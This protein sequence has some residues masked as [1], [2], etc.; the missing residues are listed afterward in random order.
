MSN[1]LPEPD[2]YIALSSINT[3]WLFELPE[4]SCFSQDYKSFLSNDFDPK[5]Y[6]N[7]TINS[8]SDGDGDITI[9]LAKLSFGIDNLNKQLHDQVTAH[10]EDL[11]TQAAGIRDLENVLSTVKEGV[12]SLNAAFDRLKENI[13]TPYA[14]IKNYTLQLERYQTASDLLRN[15]VRLFY[16]ARCLESQMAEIDNKKENRIEYFKAAPIIGELD[17]LLKEIDFEG[18]ELVQSQLPSI[19]KAKY[20]IISEAF[21]MLQEGINSQNEEEIK[22]SLQIFN[23]LHDVGERVSKYVDDVSEKLLIQI[24]NAIDVASLQKE[25]KDAGN[26][27]TKGIRW[28]GTEPLMG[29]NVAWTSTLWRRMEVLMDEICESCCKIYILEKVLSGER[30]ST[31]GL[32]YLD[33]VNNVLDGGLIQHFWKL[34]SLNFG[35]ELKEATKGFAFIQQ[36][37]VNGYPKLLRLIRDFFKKLEV[38]GYLK[39]DDVQSIAT[40][41]MGYLE[42]S[43]IRLFEPVNVAFPTGTYRIFPSKSDVTNLVRT[44]SSELE[45]AKF[46]SHLLHAV[47]KNVVKA[48]NLY[49]TKAENMVAGDV[50]AYQVTGP[51][52]CTAS[53]NINFELIN[54]LY[55]LH[56]S[57]WKVLEEYPDDITE[58][59]FDAIEH[60]RKVM[61]SIVDPLFQHIKKELELIIL[62]IHRE[63]FSRQ[64]AKNLT[65]PQ[66]AEAQCSAYMI[67]LSDRMNYIQKELLSR[68]SCGLNGKE[69]SNELGKRILYF[70]ML[71]ASLVRPLTENGKFKLTRDMG[72]LEFSLNQLLIENGSSIEELKNEYN[73]LR[74]FKQL[75]FL[76]SSQMAEERYTL[77]LPLLILIH[78]I[79][80]RSSTP[81]VAPN[82]NTIDTL[83]LPH[84]IYGWT[85]SDYSKWLDEHNEGEGIDLIKGCLRSSKELEMGEEQELFEE[86]LIRKLLKER[87]GIEV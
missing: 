3:I 86:K 82:T 59:V 5:E 52:P 4:L 64:L 7:S 1:N 17:I 29:M 43:V 15:V 83:Q 13:H 33:D 34:L 14:Q 53:Q 22:I 77:N 19:K 50:T 30:D 38:R 2:L 44:I 57:V 9:S 81:T 46:D 72:Q 51:G 54:A 35:K 6:A 67:E 39:L 10:F 12:K 40:F 65:L 47:A 49:C 25:T 75:L 80:V 24:K 32:S 66:Q 69:W 79:I 21:R 61:I 55:S 70:W 73:S 18:I 11:I 8:T 74:A 60:T 87:A 68:I 48:L 84:K 85:E 31:T 26:T 28:L 78:H 62:K 20:R 23:E 41:E 56:Q 16:L 37:L 63:D 45:V 71:H 27:S 42:R 76:E 36:S 58:V